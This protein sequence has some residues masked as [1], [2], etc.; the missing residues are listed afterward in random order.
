M[1]YGRSRDSPPTPPRVL[2]GS[3]TYSTRSGSYKQSAFYVCVGNML[4]IRKEQSVNIK[5]IFKLFLIT[6][7]LNYYISILTTLLERVMR[8]QN[9]L[10]KNKSW[11]LH[12]NNAPAHKALSVKTFLVKHNISV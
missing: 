6:I 2:S 9:E 4:S 11:I 10:W 12:Q 3:C 5:F 1:S 8:K 7:E